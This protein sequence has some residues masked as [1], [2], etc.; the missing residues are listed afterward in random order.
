MATNIIFR[1]IPAVFWKSD[2]QQRELLVVYE[3]EKLSK[4]NNDKTTNMAEGLP[5]KIGKSKTREFPILICAK[6][7]NRQSG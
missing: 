7:N 6:K 4:A 2:T 5:S 3:E 1:E